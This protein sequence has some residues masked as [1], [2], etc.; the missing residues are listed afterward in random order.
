MKVSDLKDVIKYKFEDVVVECDNKEIF[1]GINFNNTFNFNK[2]KDYSVSEIES[3]L[4]DKDD[5]PGIKIYIK[6]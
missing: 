4:S 6:K 5:N 2:Y 1:S 3:L